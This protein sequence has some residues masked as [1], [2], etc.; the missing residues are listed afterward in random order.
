M[1]HVRRFVNQEVFEILVCSLVLSHLDYANSIL[2]GAPNTSLQRL[3]IVQNWAAK[4][5]LKRKNI[6]V[7]LM[8]SDHFTG[9]Q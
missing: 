6:A 5:V 3:Q 8:L 4:L 2:I 1:M 9:F 7:Q